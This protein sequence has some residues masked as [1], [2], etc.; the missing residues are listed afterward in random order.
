[1]EIL[2]I[3]KELASKASEIYALSWKTAYQNIVPQQYLDKLPLERWTPFL[4]ESPYAG[5]I[6]KINDEYVATSSI[7]PARDEKMAGW[8]EIISLYVLPAYFNQGYG[9]KMLVYVVDQLRKEG[10]D[11]IYLWVLEE[12]QQAR[13]FYERN[14]FFPNGDACTVTI[15][16]KEL[17]E[18]RY[19]R[20]CP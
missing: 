10:F 18:L 16:G 11:N 13:R 9:K 7:A 20:T 19:T 8:G 14:G 1:M 5:Y 4:Q 3:T 6:L 12:N 15:D 2:N 17:E